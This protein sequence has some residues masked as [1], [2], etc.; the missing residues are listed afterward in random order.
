MPRSTSRQSSGVTTVTSKGT[1]IRLT[2]TQRRRALA[3]LK[4]L[5][6]Q[7]SVPREPPSK[8]RR[9]VKT[10]ETVVNLGSKKLPPIKF[11]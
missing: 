3:V 2:E 8:P 4:E 9:P 1:V 10:P 5:V 7:L 11:L 6:Q